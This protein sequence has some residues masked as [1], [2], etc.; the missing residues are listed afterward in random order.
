MIFTPFTG[1]NHHKNS[2][3]FGAAMLSNEKTESYVWLLHTFMKAMGG[4]APKL[5]ITDE[6]A[7]MKLAIQDVFTTSI[8][9]LCMWHILMKVDKVGPVLKEDVEFHQRLSWCVWSSETPTE[10]EDRWGRIMSKYELHGNEWFTK[11]FEQRK[12]WVPAYF[13]D[14]PL[15]GLLRTTSRSESAI[16]FFSRLIG[17][18][19]SLV[20]FWLRFD[21]ALEEQR[22]K[23]LE[24]DNVTLHTT[25]SLKTEGGIEKHGSEFYAHEVFSDFQIEVIAARDHCLIDSVQQE[26]DVE[27]TGIIED[28]RRS[29]VVHYNRSTMVATCPCML[30]EIHGIPC[31]HIIPA[32]RSA[33]LNEVPSY[34]LLER[35]AHGCKKKLVF[36]AD[37]TLAPC[38]RKVPATRMTQR[39]KNCF[40]RLA[41]KWKNWSCKLSNHLLLC[42]C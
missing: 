26:G 6:A 38:W 35:F 40:Q 10:F 14:I 2:V 20:E 32:L 34:Y 4:V 17:W 25:R 12:S 3:L 42:V 7:S 9:R 41:T 33:K 16:S 19:H 37:D 27:I 30:F 29:R 36:D 1:V 18:K 23:E 21:G 11:K 39:H 8:H 31:R 24:M 28:S 5:I 15:S 22:Y 13:N